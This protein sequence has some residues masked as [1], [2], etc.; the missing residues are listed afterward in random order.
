[1]GHDRARPGTELSGTSRSNEF[2]LL[3]FPGLG[4]I[5]SGVRDE[6]LC[7]QELREVQ[8]I[9][10]LLNGNHPGS[11]QA[12]QIY[13]MMQ[14]HQANLRDRVLVGVSRFD[15]LPLEGEG[16][17]QALEELAGRDPDTGALDEDL[18]GEIAGV[19]A[20]PPAG[21]AGAVR[22]ADVLRRLAVLRQVVHD[23]ESLTP[24]KERIVFLSPLLALDQQAVNRPGF[25]VG[26]PAFL[27]LLPRLRERPRRLQA[28]WS[29]LGERLA[30]SEPAA[31]LTRWLKHF[32]R[33]GGV[34]RLRDLLQEHVARHGLLQ[35]CQDARQQTAQLREQQ[36]S[37]V[38]EVTRQ[39]EA[40][41]LT[42]VAS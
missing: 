11:G 38:R 33:D 39:G 2:V 31:P 34:Q 40:P 30:T 26:S 4:A 7:N 41:A 25:A 1:V 21:A 10:I 9:V 24:G 12:L 20:P 13:N 19:V 37:Y 15:Q 3:D 28:I 8:T 22:A 32:C 18:L 27:S 16:G 17:L 29:R 36:L 42:R 35:L 5:D 23:A 6:F 14:R